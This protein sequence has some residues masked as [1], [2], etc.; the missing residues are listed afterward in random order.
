M[1]RLQLFF[2][3][4]AYFM[5]QILSYKVVILMIPDW[6]E[7][8]VV[9]F[10]RTPSWAIN[11]PTFSNWN[12]TVQKM[13]SGFFSCSS[14]CKY[15]SCFIFGWRF[16]SLNLKIKVSFNLSLCCI[17]IFRKEEESNFVIM[18]RD[19]WSVWGWIAEISMEEGDA[20][21]W[22]SKSTSKIKFRVSI[23]CIRINV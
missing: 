18:K 23:T 12:S 13:T 22:I 1:T 21:R 2:Y 8:A 3:K 17:I 4:W 9:D 20:G 16:V 19:E 15:L 11:Q 10:C 6:T 5:A 7:I 14:L